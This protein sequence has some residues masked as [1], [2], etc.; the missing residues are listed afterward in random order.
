MSF[1]VDTPRH[2]QKVA[3]ALPDHLVGGMTAPAGKSS[4]YILH[5]A[6]RRQQNVTTRGVLDHVREI[7]RDHAG[8]TNVRIADTTS[9]GALRFRQWPVALRT[10]IRLFA[11]LRLTKSPTSWLA[12]MSS[13]H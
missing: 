10:I 4:I 13:L 6:A 9:S 1:V 11:M 5:L 3:E 8:H 2:I 7:E 12:I